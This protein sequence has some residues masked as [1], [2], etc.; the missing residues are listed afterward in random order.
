MIC[1]RLSTG[2]WGSSKSLPRK[3]GPGIKQR[4]S[5]GATHLIA[6][7]DASK[8]GVLHGRPGEREAGLLLAGLI[9]GACSNTLCCSALQP[10]SLDCGGSWHAAHVLLEQ[11]PVVAAAKQEAGSRVS[12]G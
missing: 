10:T 7:D 12:V 8:V 2:Q 5:V 11:G 6:V 4:V 9:K 3:Q 1:T